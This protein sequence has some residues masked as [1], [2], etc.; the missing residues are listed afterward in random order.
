MTSQS[1]LRAVMPCAVTHSSQLRPL[2]ALPRLGTTLSEAS[3]QF[4]HLKRHAG[5]PAPR[6]GS[7]RGP[8]RGRGRSR[9][10]RLPSD[11]RAKPACHLGDRSAIQANSLRSAPSGF[12][13][14]G[15]PSEH[16]PQRRHAFRPTRAEPPED[17][18][19]WMPRLP[20]PS[21]HHG[22]PGLRRLARPVARP[23]E[24]RVGLW[25]PS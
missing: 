17:E 10:A 23:H 2:R 19:T 16:A 18:A 20:Q 22:L 13:T 11:L 14:M 24:P 6:S 12:P 9:S 4:T 15:L 7:G 25:S 21:S 1:T 5:E 8:Q 3:D